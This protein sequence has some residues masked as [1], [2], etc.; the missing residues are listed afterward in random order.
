MSHSAVHAVFLNHTDAANAINALTN[1][2]FAPGQLSVIGEDSDSFRM[3]TANLQSTKVDRLMIG[4][5]IAGALIGT[6]IAAF[7]VQHLPGFDATY[8]SPITLTAAFSG[9]AM[10]MV[11][12]LATGAIVQLD[13]IPPSESEVRLGK[14]QN[15]DMTVSVTTT[16]ATELERAQRLMIENGAKHVSIDYDTAVIPTLRTAPELAVLKSA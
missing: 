15:G 16:S 10:G 1:G 3:A 13:R 7:G 4:L 11:T 14:V 6:T 5:G 2:G 12:G 8:I 9:L